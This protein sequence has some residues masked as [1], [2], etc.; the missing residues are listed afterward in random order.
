MSHESMNDEQLILY[1]Y[2][3]GL[4]ERERA[5]I[6]AV[7]ANDAKL[8]KRYRRLQQELATFDTETPTVAPNHAVRRWHDS[9]N[10]AADME[11]ARRPVSKLPFHSWS[12]FWGA[13]VTAA[14][15]IGIGIG[16]QFAS[17]PAYE[18]DVYD[19]ATTAVPVS[20]IRSFRLHLEESRQEIARLS[21]D[22]DI[23]RTLLVMQLIDQNRLF[24][25]AAERNNAAD[26]A[27][28]L[29]AFEP[30][31]LRLAEDDITAEDIQALRRQLAFEVDAMLT[32]ISQDTS[33]ET[34]ST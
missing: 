3:D 20:F 10:R 33:E 15:A 6:E 18:Q 2:E 21:T 19:H 14:L 32:K 26:L 1:F 12:F 29:R 34:H 28:V 9:I 31:L 22:T 7:L 30:I 25:I 27:R 17:K 24:Q 16:A 8:S 11:G 23:D 4:T 13:A 5:E